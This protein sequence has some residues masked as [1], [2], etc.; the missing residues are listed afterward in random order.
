[1]SDT[2][3]KYLQHKKITHISVIIMS[4]FIALSINVF[5]IDGTDYGKNLQANI[6][7]AENA[8]QEASADI[9]LSGT[10]N[11]GNILAG[12]SMQDVVSVGLSLS[13]NPDTTVVNDFYSSL[14][15]VS[16]LSN[17]DG[18]ATVILNLENPSNID[19]NTAL[20]SF[21]KESEQAEIMNIIQAN[22]TDNTGTQYN[23]SS[24][25]YTW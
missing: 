17:T 5:L 2:I 6:L 22:F 4:L 7:G 3:T 9:S 13:Y 11:I 20:I 18:F 16:L 10:D 12:K 19:I 24:S 23:L 21:S 8:G 14:G 25:G 1:M 15:D